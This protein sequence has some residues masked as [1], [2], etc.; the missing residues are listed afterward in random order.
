MML[1]ISILLIFF[2]ITHINVLTM[3]VFKKVDHKT[4]WKVSILIP[5]RN[6]ER[7]VSGLIESLKKIKYPNLEFIILNDQSTDQTARF[8]TESID[9]DERFQTI[10][11][12]ELPDGWVGKV[13][14][15]HQLSKSASGDFFLFLDADV[16]VNS[17]VVHQALNIMEKYKSKLVTGFPSFPVRPFLAKLLVPLQHFFIF[18][19]LPNSIANRT[20]KPAFTA[21]HGAFMFFER[22]AYESIGGH[23]SVKHSLIEDIHITRVIKKSGFKATLTNITASVTCHMYDSNKEVWEGFLKNIYVGLGRSAS[24][25]VLVSIFYLVFYASPLGFAI[26]G[27]WTGEWVWLVPLLL[28]YIQTFLI[29]R[30]TKQSLYHFILMPLSAIALTVLLWSSMSRSARKVGYKWKGRVYK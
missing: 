28:V 26:A 4:S 6:E 1:F 22:N 16:R 25:A 17:M 29:D 7:N 8:L 20:T 19:H 24:G 18:F 10:D 3:P 27:L 21:A 9:G 13:H 12:K 2:L 23:E 30:A 5:M 15:C 14:A 11:G